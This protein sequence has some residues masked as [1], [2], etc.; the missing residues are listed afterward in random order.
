MV[1][2][3]VLLYYYILNIIFLEGKTTLLTYILSEQHNKKIAVILNEFG[4]DSADEK[5]MAI[6]DGGEM[7]SEWLELRLV[8]FE[9]SYLI[10]KLET[11]I[12]RE[13]NSFAMCLRFS[14]CSVRTPPVHKIWSYWDTYNKSTS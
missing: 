9:K 4:N 5:S 1:Y 3:T 14:S 10:N 8:L 6:G 2:F 11:E 13:G 12:C 7:Y